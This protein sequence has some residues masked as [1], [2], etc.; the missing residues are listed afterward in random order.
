MKIKL[1][2]FIISDFKE[3]DLNLSSIDG[4]ILDGDVH[5]NGSVSKAENEYIVEGIYSANIKSS[6]VRCLED[7]FIKLEKKKFY[8]IFL[9]EEDYF[10]YQK[11]SSEKE[12]MI[13]DNYF[14]IK[15]EEIDILEFIREQVIL[16][17][18][19]YPRCDGGCLNET[20][21]KKYGEDQPDP[22]WMGLLDI[23]IK[24]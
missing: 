7:I 20:Y 11:L 17:I 21:L 18:P 10:N 24:N 9:N 5:I 6:C 8:G 22:R 1:K 15:D 23:E 19:L 14:Q 12:I 16:D 2:E 4:I 13:N 3:F